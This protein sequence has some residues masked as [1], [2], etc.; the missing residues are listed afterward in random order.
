MTSPESVRALRFMRQLITEGVAPQEVTGFAEPDTTKLFASGKVPF[1]RGWNSA[2][3]L[4]RQRLSPGTGDKVGVAPL[5]TFRGQPYPGPSTVGGWSLYV[6]PKTEKLDAVKEFVDWLTQVPAQRLMAQ[7]SEIP[8][9]RDVRSDGSV[10]GANPALR[11]VLAEATSPGGPRLVTRPSN[12]AAY[13][14]VSKEVY[15][16]LHRALTGEAT[17]QQALADA[18]RQINTILARLPVASRPTAPPTLD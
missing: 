1:M 5:P 4:I 13:P 18:D 2:Y 6:N 17:P 3:P 15:V 8:S 14:D 11:A 12:T 16:N 9:N 10:M 7:Y